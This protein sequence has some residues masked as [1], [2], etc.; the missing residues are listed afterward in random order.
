ME[1]V[2]VL[3]NG[4]WALLG[5]ISRCILKQSIAASDSPIFEINST[6]LVVLSVSH[7][8]AQGS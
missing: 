3:N 4:G 8:E 6:M 1:G 2:N 5:G 7:L